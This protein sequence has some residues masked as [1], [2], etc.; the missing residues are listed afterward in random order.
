MWVFINSLPN[1]LYIFTKVLQ[2]LALF[3]DYEPAEWWF[4]FIAEQIL[5]DVEIFIK[6]CHTNSNES[7]GILNNDVK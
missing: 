1:K 4:E 2:L 6:I 5:S 3:C 7:A